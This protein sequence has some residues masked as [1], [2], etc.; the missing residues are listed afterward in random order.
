MRWERR[1]ESLP[2]TDSEQDLRCVLLYAAGLVAIYLVGVVVI[3]ATR[4]PTGSQLG[5][6]VIMFAPLAG[7]LLAR[8]AG[9]GVIR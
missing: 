4:T 1:T 2:G 7:A 3:A 6:L 9:S 5:V 8:F